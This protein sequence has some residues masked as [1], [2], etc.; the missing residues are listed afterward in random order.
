ME[1]LTLV[2]CLCILAIVIM[3]YSL[4]F[5]K[6]W[7]PAL[8]LKSSD[9]IYKMP[10]TIGVSYNKNN[11]PLITAEVDDTHP[12]A[13]AWLDRLPL[14][15][16]DSSFNESMAVCPYGPTA[17]TE[18]F[19]SPYA[20]SEGPLRSQLNTGLMPIFDNSKQI[21]YFTADSVNDFN[22]RGVLDGTAVN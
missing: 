1:Y 11:D 12:T 21:E 20:I 19:Y 8:K 5:R 22:L 13:K 16:L 9:K 4:N 6:K 7:Q 17:Y 14:G 3:I 2:V 10:V 15:E 18:N